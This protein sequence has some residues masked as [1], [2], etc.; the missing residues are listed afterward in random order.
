[1]VDK[2]FAPLSAACVRALSDKMYDK[3]KNAALEID[4]MVRDFATV[5]NTA[6]IKQL[7]KVLGRD[8]AGSQHS[9]SRKGGLIGLA[10]MAIALGTDTSLYMEDLLFPILACFTDS[11]SR[12]RYYA[13]ES[14]YNVVKVSR[15]R[16]LPYFNQIFAPLSKL[17]ADPD[18]NVKGG[19]DLLDRLL[20]D[21]VTEAGSFNLVEFIPLLRERIYTRNP[22]A[23]QFLV[24]WILT[25]DSVPDIDMLAFLPDLLD[26]LF[27]ILTDTNPEIKKMCET[28]L[29][30]FLHGVIKKPEMADFRAMGNILITHAQT[31]E[32]LQLTS[33]LWLKEFIT[34]YGRPILAF[35]S[36]ILTA[37]LPNMTVNED[38]FVRTSYKREIHES[39]KAVNMNLMK[40]ITSEDDIIPETN[41]IIVDKEVEQPLAA[42]STSN[43][44][45]NDEHE[46]SMN[47]EVILDIPSVLKV[48]TKHINSNS[49][50]HTKLAVL[51][52]IYHLHDKVPHRTFG[53][54][55]EIFPAV[56][57]CLCDSYDE[58]V[59]I[60][61]EVLA[62]VS[63]SRAGL[64][65]SEGINYE[66]NVPN[67]VSLFVRTNIRINMYF[68]QF[69]VNLMEE[70]RTQSRLLDDRGSYIIRQLC[71]L[72]SAED[73][74]RTLALILMEESDVQF[75][76]KIVKKL[77][78]ILLTSSELFTLRGELKE[79][80]SQESVSLFVCLYKPWCNHPVAALSLCLLTQNYVHAADLAQKFGELD[81]TVDLLTEVDKLVQLIES[82]IF[83]YLRLQLLHP[84]TYPHLIQTLFGLLMLM[85]QTETFQYLRNRLD[86][87]PRIPVQEGAVRRSNRRLYVSDIPWPELLRHFMAVQEQHR[88]AQIDGHPTVM[89]NNP[90][91]Q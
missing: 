77:N 18:Q 51:R 78:M 59:L 53:E 63:S 86:C 12:V 72:L 87:I 34:L 28:V 61:L 52:W 48:L 7:L 39:A 68:A 17:M 88:L 84:Q 89:K 40:L 58:V 41:P 70:F 43:E 13:C 26:G 46:K 60:C 20:K 21:I 44:Y 74:Y 67:S 2:E 36:G 5:D 45:E 35:A 3:R 47:S 79:L 69:L 90:I 1:M 9:H 10:S 50:V 66:N 8:F 15:E 55:K 57:L 81:V 33:L 11:D 56:M 91:I 30:E 23:R 82:P 4:R 24:S 71:I 22:F 54:M 38:E 27:L 14:L 31:D 6:Q 19:A 62:E 29:A 32:I 64:T 83:T 85:P 49:S 42:E 65:H 75:A 16:S 37:I 73:I 25:L 76:R 80:K